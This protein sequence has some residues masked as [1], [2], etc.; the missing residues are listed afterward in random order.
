MAVKKGFNLKDLLNDKSKEVNQNEEVLK[1]PEKFEVRTIDIDDIEPSKKNFYNTEDIE[2]I[3][4]SIELLG[5][6]QNL[7]VERV[8]ADKYRLLAGHRRYFASKKL[9]D[10]GKEQFRDIPCRIKSVKNDILNKLTMIMTNSTARELS[11][12]EKMHQSLEVEALVIDLKKEAGL[13]GRTRDLLAEIINISPAQ[14]GRYKAIN[15]NLIPELMEEFKCGNIVYSVAYK[16]SSLDRDIQ[17]EAYKTLER[18]GSLSMVDIEAIKMKSEENK[19]IKGQIE[20]GDLVGREPVEIPG[21]IE[22]VKDEPVKEEEKNITK[23]CEEAKEDH[24]EVVETVEEEEEIKW[25]EP[26]SQPPVYIIHQDERKHGCTFCTDS[27]NS[28]INTEEGGLE[29]SYD[30][31][32]NKMMIISKDT[33]EVQM[34]SL[35]YCPM[36]GRKL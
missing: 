23:E 35:I 26:Q 2:R 16:T 11:D 24:E 36:C 33:G 31:I 12:W 30:N 19:P 10:E 18:E 14:L 15:N 21:V 4:Q 25:S 32:A 27:C 6:E 13:P 29:L 28:S 9:V 20:I 17:K 34:I 7:I 1:G 3:K 22:V 5:I 8:G